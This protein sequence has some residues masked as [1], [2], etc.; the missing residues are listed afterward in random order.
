MHLF[1]YC[2][3]SS[4]SFT[5]YT[6][7]HLSWY[8]KALAGSNCRY[9][10]WVRCRRVCMHPCPALM[11]TG[12]PFSWLFYRND[13][14]RLYVLRWGGDVIGRRCAHMYWCVVR[15]VRQGCDSWF[16]LNWRKGRNPLESYPRWPFATIGVIAG[17]VG[18]KHNGHYGIRDIQRASVRDSI[19]DPRCRC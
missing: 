16:G 5:S 2:R 18:G 6:I 1:Y 12:L 13:R 19:G 9:V 10:F 7:H 11:Y 17:T 14:V 3:L 15:K 4:V 8:L